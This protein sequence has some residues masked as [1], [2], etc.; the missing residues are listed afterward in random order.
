M[1]KYWQLNENERSLIDY[2]FNVEKLSIS[3]IAIK[4]KRNKSTISREIKRNTV[5]GIYSF[6]SAHKKYKNRQWHK[7]MFYLEKY[8]DFT[9]CFSKWFDKKFHGVKATIHKI[10]TNVLNIKIPSFKQVY[11]WIKSKRWILNPSEKLRI[12]RKNGNKKRKV[13][14]YSKL[15][16]KR[17]FPIWLRPKHI[18]LRK[19]IDHYEIDFVIGKKANNFDNLIVITERVSRYSLVRKIR[20][21]NPMKTN[22]VIYKAFK[23]NNIKPKSITVDNGIEF[24][25]IGIL[26]HWLDCNVYYC[27]PYA[28]YQRGSNENVNG[29]IRRQYKKGTDFNLISDE[30]IIKLENKINSMPREIFGWLSSAEVYKKNTTDK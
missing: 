1:N 22:S 18:D 29:L 11:N 20:S 10:K 15:K 8:S 4:L 14:F 24:E 19:E 9:E 12:K 17:V 25:K 13:G 21:K 28:S 27:E 30:E 5:D 23:E 6:D 16:N 26:A 2:L 7:H 3:K